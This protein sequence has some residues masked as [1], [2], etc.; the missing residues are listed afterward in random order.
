M[1]AGGDLGREPDR[2]S[3]EHGFEVSR[4]RD[5]DRVG[6]GVTRHLRAGRPRDEQARSV[7]KAPKVK[8]LNRVM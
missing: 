1:V 6:Q 8:R 4:A 7:A 2:E 3:L 5:D